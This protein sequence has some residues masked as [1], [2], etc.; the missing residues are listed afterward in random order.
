MRIILITTAGILGIAAVCFVAGHAVCTVANDTNR[1]KAA[2]HP[3]VNEKTLLAEI[4]AWR[5]GSPP[6]PRLLKFPDGQLPYSGCGMRVWSESVNGFV[7]K[8]ENPDLLAAIIF[9]GRAQADSFRAAVRKFVRI[10]GVDALAR[11]VTEK[12]KS[13][14]SAFGNSELAILSQLLTSPYMAIEVVHISKDDMELRQAGGVLEEMKSELIKGNPWAAVYRKFSD[15]YPNI[16]DRA[17][18]PSS[19]RTV[20]CYQYDGVVSPTGF[21]IQYYLVTNTLP[22]L[23]HLQELFRAKQG[24]H[25]IGTPDGIYLYHIG[26]YFGGAE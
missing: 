8:I 19:H 24:T 14:P 25:V 21:D 17:K 3:Y 2:V 11:L 9:D 5:P 15:L 6:P 12:R 1:E 22:P 26:S 16:H 23:E 13:A 18:D 4:S 7:E 20:I 10:K